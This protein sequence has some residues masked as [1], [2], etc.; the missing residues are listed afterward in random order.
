MITGVTGQSDT[1]QSLKTAVLFFTG[2]E[3]S[4]VKSKKITLSLDWEHVYQA[5]KVLMKDSALHHGKCKSEN[6]SNLQS[7]CLF[8]LSNVS[9]LTPIQTDFHQI[10]TFKANHNHLSQMRQVWYDDW[11]KNVT[12]P[13]LKSRDCIFGCSDLLYLCNSTGWEKLRS[14]CQTKLESADQIWI[15]F[16]SLKGLFY[17]HKSFSET[18]FSVLVSCNLTTFVTWLTFILLFILNETATKHRHNLHVSLSPSHGLFFLLVCGHDLLLCL[19]LHPS[20]CAG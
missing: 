4:F 11:R 12:G 16:L 20:R 8:P 5:V 18:H 10:R 7:S 15:R 14:N 1:T 6:Q 2:F 17:H 13:H 3:G 9:G 19:F